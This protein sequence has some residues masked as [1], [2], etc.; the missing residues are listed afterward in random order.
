MTPKKMRFPTALSLAVSLMLV[1]EA[2]ARAEG[3]DKMLRACEILSR[4]MHV[5]GDTVYLPPGADVNQCWGF[6]SAVQEYSMLADHDGKTFLRACPPPDTTTV[7]I[8]QVFIKY[9]NAHPEKLKLKAAAVAFNAMA[10]A[11]PCR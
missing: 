9:A 5:E 10:D 2:L 11:F 8:I 4:G 7:Q 1:P 6:M 3:A